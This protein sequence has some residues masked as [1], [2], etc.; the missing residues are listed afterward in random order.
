MSSSSSAQIEQA[1]ELFDQLQAD[2]QER[3]EEDPE[4]EDFHI[5]TRHEA[6]ISLLQGLQELS[7]A[8]TDRMDEQRAKDGNASLPKSWKNRIQGL[9]DSRR[10]SLKFDSSVL[11]S[12]EELSD[13]DYTMAQAERNT[14]DLLGRVLPIR[15]P[16]AQNSGLDLNSSIQLYLEVRGTAHQYTQESELWERFLLSDANAREKKAVLDW[17]ESCARRG[18]GEL[19]TIVQQLEES[20]G[21]GKGVWKSGFLTTRERIKAEKRKRGVDSVLAS[22]TLRTSEN[23]EPL[24]TQLDPDAVTRQSR[25]LEK[26][27]DYHDRAIWLACF[28]MVRQGRSWQEIREWCE[29]RGEGWRA[30]SFGMS[31]DKQESRTGLGGLQA[32]LLWRQ[33]CLAGARHTGLD[34]YQ[35]AVYGILAGD[36]KSVDPACRSFDDLLYARYNALLIRSFE[37]FLQRA[38]P[39]RFSVIMAQKFPALTS[40]LS[41]EELDMDSADYVFKVTSNP[42]ASNDSNDPMKVL[43]ASIIADDFQR[44]ITHVGIVLAFRANQ[45]GESRMLPPLENYNYSK[46][47]ECLADD[48]DVIR[49]I[50][51]IFAIYEFIGYEFPEP[52]R[53]EIIEYVIVAYI[54][55]LRSQRKIEAI[56]TYAML[57]TDERKYRTL[58][59]MLVGIEQMDEQQ[60]LIGLIEQQ[61]VNSA[62][63]VTEQYL[64]AASLMGFLDESWRPISRFELVE[65][66]SDSRWPGYRIR[67]NFAPGD[68]KADEQ[69]LA[70]SVQWFTH[71][72]SRWKETF[73]GLSFAMRV[74]LLSGMFNGALYV[75]REVPYKGMSRA[76]TPQLLGQA[77]DVFDNNAG[78]R[79]QSPP[80]QLRRSTRQTSKQL[81]ETTKTMEPLT[82]EEQ[83]NLDM[84]RSQCRQYREMQQ[85]C[86]A[87]EHISYFKDWE[88]TMISKQMY[89]ILPLTFPYVKLTCRHRTLEH[90]KELKEILKELTDAVQ[91]LLSSFMTLIP[92]E[93]D[94]GYYTA[95]RQLYLP[96]IILAYASARVFASQFLGADVLLPA[97]ELAQVVASE[98]NKE[99]ANDFV[100][101]GLMK[102]FVRCLAMTSK[103]LVRLNQEKELANMDE[104]G[105]KRKAKKEKRSRF[106][107]GESVELW[108]PTKIL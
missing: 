65:R 9:K 56:P 57:L 92:N 94:L 24:V 37:G 21:T 15:R 13:K 69:K 84:L 55:Y 102:D 106:W 14:W 97:L 93:E 30:A 87:L 73:Y 28:A 58:G 107:E 89:V 62:R 79:E 88:E 39:D 12:G 45:D 8:V 42:A 5:R 47:Y 59:I 83:F 90:K 6:A 19:E 99:L 71:V 80:Q 33:M 44:L 82:E 51:H 23:T 72:N 77:V 100:K 64:F 50:V 91:P 108:D 18:D 7:S 98:E 68:L 2:V 66:T 74:F 43:Q 36:I 10:G 11:D 32:G 1:A 17:L 85:L 75:T 48:W 86:L 31:V 29:E 25:T 52:Y 81:D 105:K 26:S 60:L 20:A 95:I 78:A 40:T 53:Y 63:V 4:D 103:V 38:F 41:E 35:R 54:D 104:T 76:K 49:I 16:K 34:L 3:V 27:D 46:R 67:R 22:T 96:P 70:R 61:G 101:T